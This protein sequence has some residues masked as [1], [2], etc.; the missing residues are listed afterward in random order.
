MGDSLLGDVYRS[1]PVLNSPLVVVVVVVHHLG[2]LV[3]AQEK[4][5]HPRGRRVRIRG[6][7]NIRIR[8][9]YGLAD[10]LDGVCGIDD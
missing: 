3:I 7:Q 8:K 4:V 10:V 1:H 9:S 6:K 5:L 2:K